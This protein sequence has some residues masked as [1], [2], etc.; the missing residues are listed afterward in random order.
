MIEHIIFDL[1][2]VLVDIHPRRTMDEFAK[3]CGYTEEILHTF[4]LSDLHLGFM[5][6]IYSPEKFYQAMMEKFPC[7]IQIEEFR[8]IWNKVIG[9]PKPGI[10]E[11]VVQLAKDYTLSVCSNTDP[12]HWKVATDYMKFSN[13][14][15]NYF[16]SFEMKMNK[17][18]IEVFQLILNKLSVL[19]EQCVFIDDTYENIEA[20]KKLKFNC[21]YGNDPEIIRGKLQ[22]QKIL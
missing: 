14:F 12:W 3:K 9:L 20:A 5:A 2:N 11:M 19:G 8:Q 16:L 1:G 22:K 18:K 21:I 10:E 17:P 13:L 7:E 6:G 4:Y 15:S